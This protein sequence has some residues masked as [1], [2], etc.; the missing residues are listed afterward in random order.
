LFALRRHTGDLTDLRPVA[1]F[2]RGY[3]L[4][5]GGVLRL[6]VPWLAGL[7]LITEVLTHRAA[8]GVPGWWAA[9][10]VVIAVVALLW[11]A[12]ALVITSLFTFRAV[13][14]A[15]LSVYFLG[16]T[17]MVPLGSL[18]L[19]VVAFGVVYV[20]SEAALAVLAVLFAVALLRIATPMIRQVTDD[21]TA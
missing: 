13:D 21:F 4:N 20:A 3:R 12:N 10:L 2:W 9:V 5:A 14:V 15:R 7:A 18:S 6:W 17:K 1:A 11:M 8:A 16:R 19:L